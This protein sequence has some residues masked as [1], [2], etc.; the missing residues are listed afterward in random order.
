MIGVDRRDQ[1]S[2]QTPVLDTLRKKLPEILFPTVDG[3]TPYPEKGTDS[4]KG[5]VRISSLANSRDD[6]QNGRPVDPALPKPNRW[7]E[8]TTPAT[9]PA[10]AQAITNLK[11]LIKIRGTASRL[12]RIVCIM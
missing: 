2:G 8:D 9:F 10:A 12:T 3:G 4:F 11:C 5:K 7:R 1:V 6:K